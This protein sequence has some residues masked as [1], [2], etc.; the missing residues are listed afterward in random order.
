MTLRLRTFGAVYLER[1]NRPL[2]GAHS[3]RRRLV[4]LAYLAAAEGAAISREKLIALLWPERDVASGRHSLSQ[5]MYAVRHDLGGDVLTLDTE[6]VRLDGAALPSDVAI[7]GQA[8]RAGEFD[9]AVSEYR[10]P[11]LEGFHVDDAPELSRWIEEERSRRAAACTRALECLANAAEERDD[12]HQAVEWWRRRVELEATDARAT[13]RLM[14]A[15]AAVGDRAGAVRAARVYEALVREEL[16]S[17]PD[18]EVLQ[19]AE[20]LR[21]A[22]IAPVATSAMVARTAPDH[23]NPDLPSTSPPRA[24]RPSA[25]ALPDQGPRHV[26]R[27][28]PAVLGLASVMTAAYLYAGRSEREATPGAGVSASVVVGDLAGPDSTLALAVREALRAQLANTRG[29][30]LTSDHGIRELKLLMR[31]PRDASLVPPRLLAVATRS[32]AH[33]VVTGSVVPVGD[34]AQIVVELLDPRSGRSLHTVA[35]RPANA[36]AL[37]AAVE[38]IGRTLGSVISRSPLDSSIRPLPLVTTS[39]LP[40]LKSYA[41]ARQ[42]AARGDRHAAVAP[43]ERAV[44]HDSLFVLAH[45]FLGDLLWFIDEQSHAEAHLTKA[46]ALRGTVPMRERLIIRARFE[47]LVRDRAD[48]ALV[49]WDLLHDASPGDPLAYEGRTWA[50][51]ALGRHEEAAATADTAMSLD[52]GSLLPNVNN[53]M[54]SYLAVGDTAAALAIGR[55]VA[56]RFPEALLEARFFSALFRGDLAAARALADSSSRASPRAWRRHLAHLARG[57]LRAGRAE[58]DSLLADNSAQYAPNAM[59]NQGWSELDLRGDSAAAARYARQ[60]LEWTRR[61]DLSPPAVGRLSERVADLA[62]RA[63]DA[64]TVRATVALVRERDRG[65]DLPT[66]VLVD[67]T[68][69]A[70]LA[71]VRGEVAEAARLAEIARHG[72]YFSRSLATLVQLEADARRA[73]G[74]IAAADSLDRLIVTH[75]IVDGHFEAWVFLRGAAALRSARAAAGPNASLDG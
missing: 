74:E 4:V 19:L 40:A 52:A 45:Y 62:A 5:L 28:A 31:L 9:A 75:Q 38:R 1:D 26:W 46:F 17:E 53:A 8:I 72:V 69:Q 24:P 2:G 7:F 10:G 71:Y 50:L 60:A 66:Y 23:A 12:R 70:A 58:I 25:R 37:L 61:R 13:L 11:F 47:Q 16:D 6:T 51:R 56:D 18:G 20:A 55:R 41:I 73:A 30:V 3:Q 43:G 21:G 68:L 14:R 49:Y 33:I 27:W 36:G 63:G 67:R 29:V 48:T 34:G 42:I 22:P 59:I 35:E 44:T 32:G 57:D 15:L 54:Y 64:T 39:S 65:R